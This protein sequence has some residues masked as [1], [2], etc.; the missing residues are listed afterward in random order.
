[1]ARSRPRPD[2]EVERRLASG[3]ARW[4]AGCDEVGRGALGGPVTV[5]LALVD[6]EALST[7]PE[8]LADSKLLSARRREALVPL[9]E[10]WVAR[11]AVGH[12]TAAEIDERGLTAALRLAGLRALADLGHTPEVVLLDGRHD[13]LTPPAQVG[14]FDTDG[15]AVTPPV[16]TEV[17]ADRR[18][19]TVAA[20]SVL[21]KV[22]RDRLMV[23]LAH[24]F[25]SY[26]WDVNKGYGSPAHLEALVQWGPCREHR[27]SWRL[28]ERHVSD[29]TRGTSG[30]PAAGTGRLG[31]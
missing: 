29:D 23:H 7:P 12:A 10:P 11:W 5:G 17:G 3:G 19:A 24:E 18:C 14:W 9:I 31:T 25:P 13:W 4:I 28:P 22:E 20:A 21:A 26:G 1:M 30:P 8:G 6:M 15:A 27:R 2:V 16:V